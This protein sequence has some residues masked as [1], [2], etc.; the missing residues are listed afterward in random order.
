[1]T[2][3]LYDIVGSDKGM[4]VTCGD[5]AEG[6]I[7]YMEKRVERDGWTGAEA[8]FLAAI[9]KGGWYDPTYTSTQL[10][11]AGLEDVNVEVVARKQKC[12]TPK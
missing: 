5:T 6:M 4:R 8:E 11:A 12:G 7:R 3:Q 10:L 9:H 2:A 1:M